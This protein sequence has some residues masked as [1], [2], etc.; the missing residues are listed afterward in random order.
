MKSAP[1]AIILLSHTILSAILNAIVSPTW[2][3]LPYEQDSGCRPPQA[4]GSIVEWG[5]SCWIS[6]G[7]LAWKLDL[8][9]LE[10]PQSVILPS[11]G[12]CL[13]SPRFWISQDKLFLSTV[14]SGIK[15]DAEVSEATL[16]ELDSTA[17]AVDDW[18]SAWDIQ[19]E[20]G[21]YQ[22]M[23]VR[24]FASIGGNLLIGLGGGGNLISINPE[25]RDETW[26]S[27]SAAVFSNEPESLHGYDDG[28]LWHRFGTQTGSFWVS[29]GKVTSELKAWE[30]Q[31][32]NKVTATSGAYNIG[33]AGK[34]ADASPHSVLMLLADAQKIWRVSQSSEFPAE[35]VE[36]SLQLK[37]SISDGFQISLIK[38]LRR[39]NGEWLALLTH[40]AGEKRMFLSVDHGQTWQLLQVDWTSA[41]P[42]GTPVLAAQLND[43]NVV[44]GWIS[45]D[46]E[47]VDL[48]IFKI[49]D[50]LEAKFQDSSIWGSGWRH[51]SHGFIYAPHWPWVYSENHGK[52]WYTEGSF[53]DSVWLF[54]EDLGWLF[55]DAEESDWYWYPRSNCYLFKS[56]ESKNPR[57]FFSTIEGWIVVP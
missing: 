34:T 5:G 53:S 18:S 51:S 32:V 28:W 30:I 14:S 31:P 47:S 33:F 49:P 52:W 45:A 50:P 41:N 44:I 38:A 21:L 4:Q 35:L 22:R 27:G 16:I 7:R 23:G 42:L 37:S 11:M 36:A 54:D 25:N 43:G 29:L 2:I 12:F 6:T 20:E 10:N 17:I 39:I 15:L 46:F 48:G 24:S 57:W 13:S 3:S 26:L 19:I 40:P 8:P 55:T 56:P 9:S 1:L